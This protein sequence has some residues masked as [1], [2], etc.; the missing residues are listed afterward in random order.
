ML[1][2]FYVDYNDSINHLAPVFKY[3]R[4]LSIVPNYNFTLKKVLH[5][6]I[7]LLMGVLIFT[8]NCYLIFQQ[9][10][11]L[12]NEGKSSIL[13][14]LLGMALILE[15]LFY[16]FAVVYSW[17]NQQM[18]EDLFDLIFTI[19]LLN[20]MNNVPKKVFF[21]F[22]KVFM[23]VMVQLLIFGLMVMDYVTYEY[24]KL[25]YKPSYIISIPSWIY[26]HQQIYTN[27]LGSSLVCHLKNVLLDMDR[28]IEN[29]KTAKTIK[30]CLDIYLK[31]L[32]AVQLFSTLFGKHFL[33]L[34]TIS[35]VQCL[36]MCYYQ[37]INANTYYQSEEMNVG[38]LI[39]IIALTLVKIVST[40][41][42]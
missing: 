1:N 4:F 6:N 24:D 10:D 14:Q 16:I 15:L 39:L 19:E 35:S 5:R 2:V 32:K 37:Y 7:F 33:F 3:F 25:I 26:F 40:T 18:W 31:L 8:A 41:E 12:V 36:T 30:N 17:H 9:Y 22:N 20:V 34:M 42:D 23:L 21:V 29:T 13:K 11:L 38:L 28:T 27:F